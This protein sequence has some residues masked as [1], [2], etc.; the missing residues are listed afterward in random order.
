MREL[1]RE[2]VTDWVLHFIPT[3]LGGWRCRQLRLGSVDRERTVAPNRHRLYC[4]GRVFLETPLR[5]HVD[6]LTGMALAVPALYQGAF[7]LR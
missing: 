4:G 2:T 5:Q 3:P 1:C 6:S 7:A